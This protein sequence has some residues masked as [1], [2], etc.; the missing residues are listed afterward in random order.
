MESP[1]PAVA[2]RPVRRTE[3]LGLPCFSAA[4]V[5]WDSSMAQS[6]DAAV[7]TCDHLMPGKK[8]DDAGVVV[9]SNIP[10]RLYSVAKFLC[11]A[12]CARGQAM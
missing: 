2:M 10:G 9:E 7:V 4:V 5:T 3:N 8:L 12:Q 6:I 11:I 1:Y